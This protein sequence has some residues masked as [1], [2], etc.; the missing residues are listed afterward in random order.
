MVRSAARIENAWSPSVYQTIRAACGIA[1]CLI[2]F[3]SQSRFAARTLCQWGMNRG[4]S[5]PDF[6]L[7]PV[8]A[9]AGRLAHQPPTLGGVVQT[10]PVEMA[11]YSLTGNAGS[12]FHAEPAQTQMVWTRA[13]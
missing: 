7:K 10:G 9:S 1:S 5:Q 12:P 6:F 13:R 11:I 3:P 4:T 2:S 8:A